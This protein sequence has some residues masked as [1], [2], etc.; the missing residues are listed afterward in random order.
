[1]KTNDFIN[2]LAQDHAAQ[3]QPQPLR[4]TFLTAMAA[5]LGVAVVAFALTLG[6]RPDVASA[7]LT[8]RYDFKFVVTLTLAVTSARLVWRLARPAADFRSA[9]LA[10]AAAPLLLFG[11]VLYEL[12]AM[13]A[14]QLASARHRL[15][16][17]GVPCEHHVPLARR[18][19]PP[20]SMRYGAAHRCGRVWR[21]P[22]RGCSPTRLPQRYTPRIARTTRRCSSPSGTQLRWL[23]SPAWQAL[24]GGVCCA[25]NSR[26]HA[27]DR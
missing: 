15:E 11:A 26:R 24:P 13:P 5:G 18:R 1:M 8:W 20:R 21:A 12:W 23:L 27:L 10:L 9:E 6:V 4:W 7:I 17:R 22:Q 25:G 3:P 16:F 2:A 19:L 14:E